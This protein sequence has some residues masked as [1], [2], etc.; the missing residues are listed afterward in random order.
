MSYYET[1]KVE[2]EGRE[3][4]LCRDFEEALSIFLSERD[5]DVRVHL[6]FTGGEWEEE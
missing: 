4:I 6:I 3:I 1:W 5:Y 2:I